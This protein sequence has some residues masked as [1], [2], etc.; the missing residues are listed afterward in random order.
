MEEIDQTHEAKCSQTV[1]TQE[2]YTEIHCNQIVKGQGGRILKATG[3]KW[4]NHYRGRPV[5]PSA[6][7]SAETWQAKREWYDIC[8]ELKENLQPRI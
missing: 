3:E 2:D 5:K 8:K 6:G 7:S 4:L 1:S